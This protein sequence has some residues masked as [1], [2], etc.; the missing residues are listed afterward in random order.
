MISIVIPTYNRANLLPSALDSIILQS[1][2]N[3]ECIVVDDYSTD[4]TKSLVDS[5][6]IMDP[7][8]SYV[9]NKRKKGAQGARNTGILECKYDWVLLLDSDNRIEKDYV[10]HILTYIADHKNIDVITNYIKIETEIAD[11]EERMS[12]VEGASDANLY[13]KHGE[14]KK[15][16]KLYE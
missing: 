7:R 14:L 6:A 9:L 3:W 11:L 8:I 5:Y 1:N 15:A 4:G 12:T 13:T 10:E 16:G 2:P